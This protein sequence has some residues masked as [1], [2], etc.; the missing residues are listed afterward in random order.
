MRVSD[1]FRDFVLDQLARVSDVRA[2]AMFGGIGL[3][4]EDIF[5]GLIAADALYFKV[6]DSNREQYVRAGS[7]AF[8]PYAD[9]PMTMPYFNLP[10]SVMDDA[11]MLT[12]WAA[13][14][15]AVARA[16]QKPKP[17]R[18]KR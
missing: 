7:K 6:D 8:K 11:D 16:S 15:V 5:F 1:S 12:K 13:Q 3:Y 2:R 10:A 18:P 14:S 17:R 9:R 4:S